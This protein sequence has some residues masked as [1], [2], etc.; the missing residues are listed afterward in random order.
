L[1]GVVHK[2]IHSQG[3]VSI[4][5]MLQTIN[6]VL[7]IRICKLFVAKTQR[8]FENYDMSARRGRG[9]ADKGRE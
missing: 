3:R 4:V 1:Q 8:F 6:G 9:G 7:Q 2:D 5:D